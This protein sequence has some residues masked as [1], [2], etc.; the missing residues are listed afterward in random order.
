MRVVGL[1]ADPALDRAAERLLAH[2]TV[3][4]ERGPPLI[5]AEPDDL[6][7]RVHLVQGDVSPI[8][9]GLDRGR[10]LADRRG[11]QQSPRQVRR[12]AVAR[13]GELR[14]AL[15]AETDVEVTR[16]DLVQVERARVVGL[17]DRERDRPEAG[18]H[19]VRRQAALEGGK[20]DDRRGVG[21]QH[22]SPPSLAVMA[23]VYML[24][25]CRGRFLA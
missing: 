9:S 13:L 2:A 17:L 12:E 19:L 23:N 1:L 3:A 22:G 15:V 21:G 25:V 24:D 16:L 18:V 10:L 7:Q 11:A 6:P 5:L 8:E 4:R 14:G 20:L